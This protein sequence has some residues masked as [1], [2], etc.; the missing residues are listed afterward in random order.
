LFGY[1]GLQLDE[2]LLEQQRKAYAV[3]GVDET[4]PA[5]QQQQKK[6]KNG[7]DDQVGGACKA[8]SAEQLVIWCLGYNDK[9]QQEEE[10]E[11]ANRAQEHRCLRDISS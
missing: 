6:R 11:V 10:T 5:N 1:G 9:Q 3:E 4:Q 7:E 2:A 8:P